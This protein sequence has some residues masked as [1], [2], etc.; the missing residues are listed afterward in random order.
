M[1]LFFHRFTKWITMSKNKKHHHPKKDQQGEGRLYDSNNKV[2]EERGSKKDI[3][4]VDQQEGNMDNGEVGGNF[5]S[6]EQQNTERGN[7]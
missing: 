7:R 5:R 4:R 2:A 6:N 3:S 1:A